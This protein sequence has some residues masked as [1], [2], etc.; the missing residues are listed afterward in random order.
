[1]ARNAM[2]DEVAADPRT[3][4]HTYQGRGDRCRHTFDGTAWR[5]CTRHGTWTIVN[6]V[7]GDLLLRCTQHAH[8]WIQAYPLEPTP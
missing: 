6:P 1:M 4:P 3:A 2:H 7:T 5:T 8:A